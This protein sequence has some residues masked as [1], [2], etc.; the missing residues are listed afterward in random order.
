MNRWSRWRPFPDPRLG[1][2]LSA[3]FGS[4]VYELRN[5]TTRKLVYCGEGGNVAKRMTSLLPDRAG[6]AGTRKNVGLSEYVCANLVDIE[7]RTKACSDKAAAR[8][9][10]NKM[11][12]ENDYY[13]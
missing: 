9:E 11:H 10:E 7:F 3:P 4:G 8:T 6:G 1:G 13:F 2:Y 5:R 12:N